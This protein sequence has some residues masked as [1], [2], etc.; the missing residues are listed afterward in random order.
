M[1]GFAKCKGIGLLELL[2]ALAILST[3]ILL[4]TRYY[5]A[6]RGAQQVTEAMKIIQ[7]VSVAGSIMSSNNV[8]LST[9][10]ALAQ[11]VTRGS[12]PGDFADETVNP[13]QGAVIARST[14]A[15]Q[16]QIELTLVP[17]PLCL[18]LNDKLGK[19]LPGV[20]AEED[21]V[22]CHTP[23]TNAVCTF[24]IKVDYQ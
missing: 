12:V 21:T 16:L 15:K 7:S 6:T 11:F 19:S 22:R 14:A 13:W 17:E 18:N 2:L 10:D 24:S 1:Y 3:M 23:C 4:A 20:V 9:T 8:A 5:S